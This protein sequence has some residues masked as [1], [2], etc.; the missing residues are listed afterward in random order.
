MFITVLLT[1][2]ETA[3]VALLGAEDS[4]LWLM[5]TSRFSAA[6]FESRDA[7]AL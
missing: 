5:R 4:L 7:G 2:A 3:G 1:V 6:A